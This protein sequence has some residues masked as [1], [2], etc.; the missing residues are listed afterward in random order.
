MRFDYN[1]DNFDHE[2]TD[3]RVKDMVQD[4]ALSHPEWVWENIDVIDDPD[5]ED[6]VPPAILDQLEDEDPEIRDLA[7]LDTGEVISLNEDGDLF[8]LT[9]FK[10]LGE[11]RD[12][13]WSYAS[14]ST[15]EFE[16]LLRDGA[17]PDHCAMALYHYPNAVSGQE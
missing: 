8:V 17:C 7:S 12:N 6:G 10:S 1:E 3:G 15:G 2:L 4:T 9:D 5:P 11:G 13:V 16:G 14:A